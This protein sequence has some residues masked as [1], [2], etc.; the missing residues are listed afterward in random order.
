M[1]GV[2]L[3]LLERP[4]AAQAVLAAAQRSATLMGA[5]RINV[6]AIRTPPIDIL[7]ATEGLIT[8]PEETPDRAAEEMRMSALHAAFQAWQTALP[9]S[10]SAEW[11]TLEGWPDQL[12]DEWGERADLIV[13]Q[14]PA[15]PATEPERRAV[16]AALFD[17]GRPVLVVPQDIGTEMFGD[18]V[19]VAWRDDSRTLNA[20][21]GALRW[22]SGATETH[23]LAGT[24]RWE[25]T[26]ELPPIFAEHGVQASFEIMPMGGQRAFGEA[27][28]SRAHELKADIVVLGAFAHPMLFGPLLGGVTKH[29]LANADMP[30]L[31]RY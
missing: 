30:V 31:M 24:K 6:L 28:L 23:V 12:V 11:Q 13:L 20:V 1:S 26:P 5:S 10:L 7:S 9:D 19:L 25:A 27:L 4:A 16:Y 8:L 18:R 3:A 22:L 17:T 14:R 29:M 15:T 21:M 2:V